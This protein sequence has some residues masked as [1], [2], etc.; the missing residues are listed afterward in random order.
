LEN[1]KKILLGL[2][3]LLGGA[4][5][6][7]QAQKGGANFVKKLIPGSGGGGSTP[8]VVHGGDNNPGNI[9]VSKTAWTGKI[10]PVPGQV[11]ENFDSL[12]DGTKALYTN[13]T[14]Y[15]NNY[16]LKTVRTIISTWAPP[17]DNNDT[18]AYI[19]KVAGDLGIVDTDPV[20]LDELPQI[21]S[22]ISQQEGNLPMSLQDVNTE[23]GLNS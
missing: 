6:Y 11:F 17:S 3:L 19:T 5:A 7:G 13:L 8:P 2:G 22:S 14:T 15:Y 18:E 10:A 23:L 4:V 20:T 12:Q 21:V 16:G 9:R 1:K